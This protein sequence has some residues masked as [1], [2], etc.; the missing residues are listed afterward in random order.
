MD[1]W[2]APSAPAASGRRAS[3]RPLVRGGNS[4]L[5]ASS[6]RLPHLVSTEDAAKATILGLKE[7]LAGMEK[8]V[9][10][11]KVQIVNLEKAE[12]RAWKKRKEQYYLT[13]MVAQQNKERIKVNE[14]VESMKNVLDWA[15]VGRRHEVEHTLHTK[16][17]AVDKLEH[18]LDKALGKT[19]AQK[20][21]ADS[22]QKRIEMLQAIAKQREGRH[23]DALVQTESRLLE[24]LEVADRNNAMLVEQ[25]A[26]YEQMLRRMGQDLVAEK[27]ETAAL[28][29]RIVDHNI[30]LSLQ[31]MISLKR[32]EKME[33]MLGLL[34]EQNSMVVANG[35]TSIGPPPPH[36][37]LLA[38]C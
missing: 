6:G 33:K 19:R 23:A 9:E 2:A 24:Q 36:S 13:H 15:D 14:K 4:S 11:Q 16:V 10:S 21:K 7:R 31:R 35:G 29:Q 38:S 28:H 3:S 27:K 8:T 1:S 12:R 32:T 5:T 20:S 37:R 18:K 25:A 30:M 22:L 26:R 17:V 34:R